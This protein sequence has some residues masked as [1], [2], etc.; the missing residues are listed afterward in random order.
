MVLTRLQ[1]FSSFCCVDVAESLSSSLLLLSFST[2][3]S[4]VSSSLESAAIVDFGVSEGAGVEVD[5]EMKAA[6]VFAERVKGTNG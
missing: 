2:L 4:S 3:V 1:P 6:E 5:V